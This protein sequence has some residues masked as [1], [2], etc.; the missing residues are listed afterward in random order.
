MLTNLLSKGGVR[1]AARQA[2][3][4]HARQCLASAMASFSSDA[5]IIYTYTDEAPALATHALLPIIRRFAAPANVKIEL[6]DI[7][8]AARI[9][10]HFPDY[11][12]EDQRVP[13]SLA[14]LGELT[15]S[16]NC[17]I[18]KLPNVSDSIPQLEEAIA[19][20]QSQGYNVP[21]YPAEPTTDEEREINARY[22]G[23]LGSA[24]NPVL[25]EGNSDRRVADPVKKYA[26]ANPHR[27]KAWSSDSRTHVA[28]MSDGDFFSTEQSAIVPSATSVQIELEP[29]DGEAYALRGTLSLDY[30]FWLPSCVW[31]H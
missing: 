14:E 22:A 20:L 18:I 3:R 19:E 24:V 31:W 5:K 28:H 29:T 26:Q 21:N 27:M 1:L 7:S 6:S 16:P 25:R 13:D 2:S 30:V 17:N 9:L 10:A 4:R 23:V 8:V 15:Q 11:L 12:T